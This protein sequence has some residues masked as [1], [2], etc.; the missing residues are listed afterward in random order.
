MM[1]HRLYSKRSFDSER[2]MTDYQKTQAY[3]D[4]RNARA[5]NKVTPLCKKV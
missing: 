2:T 4:Y 3:K 5:G 1:S